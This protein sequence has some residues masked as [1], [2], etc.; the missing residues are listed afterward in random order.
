M[1]E[2]ENV[3]LPEILS[4]TLKDIWKTKR[5]GRMDGRENSIPTHKHS[6]RG[7][8]II[9]YKGHYPNGGIIMIISN[10]NVFGNYLIESL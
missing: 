4:M 10:C 1:S 2:G 3:R 5:Y 9:Y 8:I 7:G 6:L